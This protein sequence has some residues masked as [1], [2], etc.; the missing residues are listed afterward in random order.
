[1]F[2][3]ILRRKR[4]GQEL[5]LYQAAHLTWKRNACVL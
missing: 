3:C 5:H 4:T 1:M 2:E